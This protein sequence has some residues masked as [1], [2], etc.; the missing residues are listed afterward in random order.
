MLCKLMVVHDPK[1]GFAINI[2]Q[3]C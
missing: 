2:K 1:P 3:F